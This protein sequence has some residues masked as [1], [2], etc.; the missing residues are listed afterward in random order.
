MIKAAKNQK[1]VLMQNLMQQGEW[2]DGKQYLLDDQETGMMH[3]YDA[4]G[5]IISSRR[6]RPEERQL[7]INAGLITKAV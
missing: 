6:L 7:S 1:G 5:Q 3:S 4:S 2:L